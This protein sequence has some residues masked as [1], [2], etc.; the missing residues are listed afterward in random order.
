LVNF[1]YMV[2]K[3]LVVVIE[4]HNLMLLQPFFLFSKIQHKSFLDSFGVLFNQNP[5]L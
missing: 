3:G 5:F 4:C 2:A 1:T